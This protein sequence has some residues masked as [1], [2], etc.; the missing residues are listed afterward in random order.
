MEGLVGK[1][2]L[3]WRNKMLL[4]FP[5][6]KITISLEFIISSHPAIPRRWLSVYFPVLAQAQAR[7]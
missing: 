5:I 4:T 2:Q 1:K 3:K 6:G 7:V